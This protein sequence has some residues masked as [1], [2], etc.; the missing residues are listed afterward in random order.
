LREGAIGVIDMST[1][2]RTVHCAEDVL[3]PED[4][5]RTL[6][7]NLPSGDEDT[8]TG[9]LTAAIHYVPVLGT[10]V[11]KWIEHECEVNLPTTVGV[12]F[13]RP[14]GY[15]LGNGMVYPDMVGEA[16]DG[17]WEIWFE[18]KLGSPEG[19]R[20]LDGEIVGQLE[21]YV[22]AA[23]RRVV[24][25]KPGRIFVVFCTRDPAQCQV[26]SKDQRV[27]VLTAPGSRSLR[28]FALRDFLDSLDESLTSSIESNI[29][30]SLRS[31]WDGLPDMWATADTPGWAAD[32]TTREADLDAYTA[33][34][35]NPQAVVLEHFPEG[36]TSKNRKG[37]GFYV[38]P[39]H[40]A[41]YQLSFLMAK[42][43]AFWRDRASA[44]K[45]VLGFRLTF[46]EGLEPAGSLPEF[47][48]RVGGNPMDTKTVKG[49]VRWDIGLRLPDDFGGTR[50]DGG[51]APQSLAKIIKDLLDH[52]RALVG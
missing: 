44:P 27:T 23:N 29:W 9:L 10:R 20:V 32:Q 21:A 35:L 47:A 52:V 13:R 33:L 11:L 42:P 15:A 43:E 12:T 4:L 40:P 30:R 1:N 26:V 51:N 25:E 34:W 2:T 22:D 37:H 31:Y 45:R 16:S 49:R 28:W 17:T 19:A 7:K 46:N 14:N 36:R 5:F 38:W 41:I 18:H 50:T 6:A 48:E 39:R 24:G 8:F 3:W